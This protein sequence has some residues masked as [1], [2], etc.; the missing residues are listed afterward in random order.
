MAPFFRFFY[1][2]VGTSFT[3]LQFFVNF[4]NRTV[5]SVCRLSKYVWVCV[6]LSSWVWCYTFVFAFSVRKTFY[7]PRALPDPTAQIETKR[8]KGGWGGVGVRWTTC[9]GSRLRAP[10]FQWKKENRTAVRAGFLEHFSNRLPTDDNHEDGGE[11]SLLWMF[12]F[13][14]N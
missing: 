14:A 10:C 3:N 11:F 5:F 12:L 13:S 9:W 8:A 1:H 6:W 2:F 4:I 7:L